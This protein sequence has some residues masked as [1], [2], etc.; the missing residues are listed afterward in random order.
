[1]NHITLLKQ[2][3]DAL[4]IRAEYDDTYPPGTH[5]LN[6][7][8]VAAIAL[9][10]AIEQPEAVGYVPLSDDAIDAIT[11]TQWNTD[12]FLAAHRAYARAIERAVRGAK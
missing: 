9:R 3:L 7:C 12:T 4:E 2:A 1:M 5:P 10:A 8:A 11:A 6:D